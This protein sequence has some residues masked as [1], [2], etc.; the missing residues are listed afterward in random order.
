MMKMKNNKRI[1]CAALILALA[2]IMFSGCAKKSEV[3]QDADP[4][5]FTFREIPGITQEEINAIETLQNKY[6]HFV[7]AMSPSTEVFIGKNGR[8]HGFTPLFCSWLTEVFGIPIEIELYEFDDLQNKLKSGNIDLTGDLM[9][10]SK[11]GASFIMS[12][13]I[14][15]R[16][17]KIYR[18]RNGNSFQ[19]IQ[20]SRPLRL[21]FQQDLILSADVA[22]NIKYKFETVFVD[23]YRTAYNMMKN[24]E[25]DAFIGIN[26]LD[27]S[28]DE[29]D[30]VS[31]EDIY[32]LIFQGKCLSAYRQEFAPLISALNKALNDQTLLYL[33]R[34]YDEGKRQYQQNKVYNLLTEE[35]KAYIQNHQVIPIAVEY[36]N[37]PI[38]FYDT[39]TH[40]LYGIYFDV[41]D[42]ISELT[43][44]RFKYA[45]EQR[46]KNQVLID[47]LESGEA[48][49]MPELFRLNE[50]EGRFIWSDVPLLTDSFAFLSKSN[51]QDI[52]L[53]NVPYLKT[54]V[55]SDSIY[56]D[57]FKQM[58]PDH[59]HLSMYGSQEEVWESLNTD[60]SDIIFACNRRLITYTNF[61]E[62]AGYKLNLIL[63]HTFDSSFG[64]NKNAGVLKS[65]VDKVLDNININNISNQWMHKSYDYRV[66]VVASRLPWLVSAAALFFI[67]LVLVLYMYIRSRRMG[68]QLENLVKER[69]SALANES[70]KLKT[71]INSIP[72]FIFSKD[73]DLKYTQCNEAYEQFMGFKEEN[74]LG[75]NNEE[76]KWFSVEEARR[77]RTTDLEV[78]K[79]GK[80]ITLEENLHS[81]ITHEE[82]VFETIK[83]P[84]KRDGIV[85]GMLAVKRNITKRKEMEDEVI[86]ASRA[87]SDFLANM[88]HE[89]RTPLNVVIGL[90]DLTLEDEGM[91]T[92]VRNNLI[93]ISNAGTTLLNIVNDILDISKI[94]SGKLTLT[95]VEYYL[96]SVLNDI[97]TL[98]VTRLG[99]KPIKFNLNIPND[100]PNKL[101]G[102]DLRVKQVFTNLLTNSVKY[103]HEGSID[104]NVNCIRDGATMWMDVAVKDTGIGI[105]E[106]DLKKL[107]SNYN[108]VDTK[109]NRN[110]EGTGLGLAI[111]KRLVE[112]MGGE[113]HVES[114]Y[115]KGSTFSFRIKQG[116]VSDVVLGAEV[117]DKLRSFCYSDDKHIATRKLVRCN[118]SYARVLVVDD[119][120]TNLD[121][122]SGILRKYKMGVDVLSNG[123]DAVNRIKD[124]HPVYNAIFM[125][126]MMPGMDGIETVDNIR[127]IGTE[128]AKNIPIIALTANA[129]QGTDKMFYEHDFQDFTTKPIDVMEM[130][131]ILRKWVR[132][133][134]HGTALDSTQNAEESPD[135]LVEEE[136]ETISIEIPGVDTKKGLS[137][138]AG[139]KDIYLPLLR[140][141]IANTPGTLE[142][143]RTVTAGTLSDY[144][145]SVHGLKG[146]SAGIGAEEVREQAWE[147]E[148]LSR[149]G[150]LQSVL[151]KNSRLIADAEVIVENVKAW[152][153]QYDSQNAKP[154]L[155]APDRELLKKLKECCDNYDMS[156]IDEVIAELDKNDYEE[157]ADLVSWIKEKI[158]ISEI[159]EVADRLAGL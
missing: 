81:I 41:L 83:A 64:Y 46:V 23:N 119:M 114:E 52:E 47:M 68:A 129:I 22:A 137:L 67:V 16:W 128:Y 149:A 19:N 135:D 145:I 155:K 130:D 33:A 21:A 53:S 30:D 87:K 49:I 77:M 55:R 88:S 131:K 54:V 45:N 14:V 78:I 124:A 72:D 43:G 134:T 62:E 133:D 102:D 105:R 143:L 5:K 82:G 146:T 42:K 95:P 9:N 148:Q 8:I 36:N 4:G 90:T 69:T 61:Y 125:D 27:A 106:E 94:E 138:Y 96:P 116:F 25:V 63:D 103:T 59:R 80:I 7:Y 108:Q 84:I 100:L 15:E 58:F 60:E 89:L 40:K 104:F 117:S 93:K 97:I 48:L 139:E 99:E 118:L 50:Y 75:V 157:D 65:I 28:F 156:G 127:A 44:L 71:L 113:I 147:L 39:N 29:Y 12:K 150:N 31:N 73:T 152:L 121:V 126:H 32:P 85:I 109:A 101:F 76:G 153:A 51:F 18:I 107:F 115:G 17:L 111:T 56:S 144:V 74:I 159:G 57:F 20:R 86:A 140:S 3:K 66:K 24:G 123:R 151:E 6:R 92:N 136:E 98:V 2:A 10:T 158:V 122:A 38:S 141:Y 79:E 34:L 154:R 91:S 37:Y 11:L 70:S 142:K 112:M 1:S 13:P 120:L 132:K 35:E 110:I 26:T